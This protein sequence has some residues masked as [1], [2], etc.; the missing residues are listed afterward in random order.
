MFGRK[1]SLKVLLDKRFGYVMFNEE[2]NVQIKCTPEYKETWVS[3]G[4]KVIL[5]TKNL[6]L[7]EG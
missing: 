1:S 3:L 6:Q 4:F 2:D 7:I 5:I